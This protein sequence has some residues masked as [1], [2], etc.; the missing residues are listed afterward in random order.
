VRRNIRGLRRN[1]DS[2]MRSIAENALT[3][4]DLGPESPADS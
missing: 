3:T 1:Q 2:R 4:T